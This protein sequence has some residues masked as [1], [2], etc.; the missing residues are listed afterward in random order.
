MSGG[1]RNSYLL[2]HYLVQQRNAPQHWQMSG[3]TMPVGKVQIAKKVSVALQGA[4][5]GKGASERRSSQRTTD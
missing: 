3:S 1:R 2:H 4:S 5:P